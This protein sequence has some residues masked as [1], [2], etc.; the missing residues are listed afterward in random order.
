MLRVK[1]VDKL[2]WCG[3]VNFYICVIV[4]KNVPIRVDVSEV[5]SKQV[6]RGGAIFADA[7]VSFLLRLF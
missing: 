5:E 3:Y 7:D 6:N 4:V 2:L 1:R